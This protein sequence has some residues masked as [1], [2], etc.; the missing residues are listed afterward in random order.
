MDPETWQK[1]CAYIATRSMLA[2]ARIAD[3]AGDACACEEALATARRSLQQ[4]VARRAIRIHPRPRSDLA[5]H[6]APSLFSTTFT[7]RGR[8]RLM[9]PDLNSW[10][11][12][13]AEPRRPGPAHR[14]RPEPSG[15]QT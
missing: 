11:S 7:R 10:R 8:R 6:E 1:L 5:T 13:P 9:S 15:T 2:R 3:H 14:Q 12:A 4:G